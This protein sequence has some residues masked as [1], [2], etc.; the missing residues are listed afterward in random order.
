[1]FAHA[2]AE[3][4]EP[5]R[6]DATEIQVRRP[7][8]GRDDRRAFLSGKKKQTTMKAT[9][10]AVWRRRTLWTDALQS[11]GRADACV[12]SSDRNVVR[13]QRRSTESRGD[14]TPGRLGLHPGA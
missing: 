3:G 7:P 8:T 9:V 13:S 10:I 2:R 5:R 14:P 11:A 4:I 12:T 1:M 6:L